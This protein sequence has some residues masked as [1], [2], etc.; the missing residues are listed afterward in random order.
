M[1]IWKRAANK[2][3]QGAYS[4]GD[5]IAAP[6]NA[7]EKG[8]YKMG[9]V[10]A[11]TTGLSKLPFRI[12]IAPAIK[13]IIQAPKEF[14]TGAGDVLAGNGNKG[15][16]RIS[17]ALMNP[18]AKTAE[19]ITSPMGALIGMNPINDNTT[20]GKKSDK[21]V[22]PELDITTKKLPSKNFGTNAETLMDRT[23]AKTPTITADNQTVGAPSLEELTKELKKQVTQYPKVAGGDEIVSSSA[24]DKIKQSLSRAG[25]QV[26]NVLS[27][28]IYPNL[29][30]RTF[31]YTFKNQATE[32]DIA[33]F[34]DAYLRN[35]QKKIQE[36]INKMQ[37]RKQRGK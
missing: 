14:I 29:N 2:I 23:E 28:G 26:Q 36:I 24:L 27:E 12:P 11:Q 7:T 4:V 3:K 19:V 31:W 17:T 8:L 34:E 33:E 6:I 21:P 32:K 9:D 10:V 13:S 25:R 20:S 37:E 18:I 5:A 15:L 35:D 30:S 16:N 1:S 22:P